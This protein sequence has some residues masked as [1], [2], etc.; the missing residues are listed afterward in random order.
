[1][2]YIC[3]EEL[4]YQYIHMQSIGMCSK[5]VLF[6]QKLMC[7]C[8]V[9]L[10]SRI[11]ICASQILV[12]ALLSFHKFCLLVP[13]CIYLLCSTFHFHLLCISIFKRL[14]FNYCFYLGHPAIKGK[15]PSPLWDKLVFN[16]IKAKL[17]GRVRVL[18][19]G[20]SPLS[21][22]ILEFLKM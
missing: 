8:R 20:A 4:I 3:K 7:L 22:D 18:A 10:I 19:S 17:G 14:Q 15:S 5:R 11:H 13:T 6:C 16:K 1:M 9:A 12:L 2:F 21:P